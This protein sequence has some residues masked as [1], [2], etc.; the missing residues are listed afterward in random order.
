MRAS[1]TFELAL[2]WSKPPLNLNDRR[3]HHAQAAIVRDVRRAGWVLAR[4]SLVGEHQ[5]V[6]VCLHYQPRDTRT[7]DS[8]NPV[9]TL[10]ALCDGLVDARVVPDDDRTRMVKDMPVIHDPVKGQPGRLWLVIEVLA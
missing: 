4:S 8:E 6:R 7:R 5:R 10:K 3:H 9:P 1:T 2:P